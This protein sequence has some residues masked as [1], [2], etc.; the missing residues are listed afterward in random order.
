VSYCHT[1]LVTD[2]D[3]DPLLFGRRSDAGSGWTIGHCGQK[4]TLDNLPPS[5]PRRWLPRLKADVVAAV[6]GGLLTV[7]E[8]C[9][10]YEL[11]VQELACWTTAV[12]TG[13]L[14]DLQI[15]RIS[16]NRRNSR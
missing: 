10:R 4:L 3:P 8:A 5:K 7:D 11:S 13:G 16:S 15:K 1:G 14:K 9:D 2:T 6:N 12:A